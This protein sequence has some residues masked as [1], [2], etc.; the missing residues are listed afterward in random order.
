MLSSLGFSSKLTNRTQLSFIFKCLCDTVILDDFKTAL[1]HMRTH[2]MRKKNGELF[3]TPL[4]TPSNSPRVYRKRL[5]TRD[6][7]SKRSPSPGYSCHIS[8]TKKPYART[9]QADHI[10]IEDEICIL[11]EN[12]RERITISEEI[13]NIPLRKL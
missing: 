11:E 12:N 5:D 10:R 9:V 1:D 4:T 3:I 8:P 6:V 7:E 2:W 13:P